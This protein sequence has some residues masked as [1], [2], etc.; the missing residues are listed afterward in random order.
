MPED[1]NVSHHA[2]FQILKFVSEFDSYILL[3]H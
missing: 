3:N 2:W 1:G